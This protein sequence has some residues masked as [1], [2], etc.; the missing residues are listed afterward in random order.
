VNCKRFLK[1]AAGLTAGI[2]L[3]ALPATSA[4]AQDQKPNIL[5]VMTDDVGFMSPS[6]YHQG[7]MVGETPNIDRIGREGVRFMDAYSE[8]SCTA[9]ATPL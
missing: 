5:F 1:S 6:I 3:A 8:Q 7:L 4:G 9:G 2:G